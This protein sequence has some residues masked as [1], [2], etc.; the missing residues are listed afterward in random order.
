MATA[1][2]PCIHETLLQL[3]LLQLL[4]GHNHCWLQTLWP[5]CGGRLRTL[6]SPTPR[7]PAGSRR[8]C[9]HDTARA[10]WP[11]I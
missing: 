3:T 8:T 9:V 2:R 4:Q 11:R 10:H 7:T 1:Q 5:T 6:R